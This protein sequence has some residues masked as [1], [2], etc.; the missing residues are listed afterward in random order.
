[1]SDKMKKRI[2]VISVALNLVCIFSA[3]FMFYKKWSFNDI[4][5]EVVTVFFRQEATSTIA[6]TYIEKTNQFNKL[7]VNSDSIVFVG[8]S[9]TDMGEWSEIFNNPNVKN[10]GIGGDNITGVLSRIGDIAKQNP[11]SIFLMIGTNNLNGNPDII[12]LVND[13]DKIITTIRETSPNTKIYVQSVLPINST[14]WATDPNEGLNNRK[15]SN[16]D[17]QLF[18]Q[19]IRSLC[20]NQN[21]EYINLYDKFTDD[22]GNLN[23]VYSDEGL[24]LNGEG[25]MLWKQSV[26]KFIN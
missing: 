14:G 13:Y 20:T 4:A 25:Y 10:R 26:E 15:Q 5:K 23:M 9:I 18:N 7:N 2:I 24:H 17:I 12:S 21:M 11:K 16:K 8:D 22:N 3:M 19:K 6:S 1:M